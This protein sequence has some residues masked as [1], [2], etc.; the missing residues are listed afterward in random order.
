MVSRREKK[1]EPDGE[2]MREERQGEGGIYCQLPGRA[3]RAEEIYE[4]YWLY[5]VY[6]AKG[7]RRWRATLQALYRSKSTLL[8]LPLALLCQMATF[9]ALRSIFFPPVSEKNPFLGQE[10]L[11]APTEPAEEVCVLSSLP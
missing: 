1:F 5:Q 8:H 7:P 2:E 11:P 9:L 4:I 3:L 6:S 10:N